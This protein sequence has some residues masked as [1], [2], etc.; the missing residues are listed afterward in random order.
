M[1]LK[2]KNWRRKEVTKIMD[3]FFFFFFFAI[4]LPWMSYN[5]WLPLGPYS[6]KSMKAVILYCENT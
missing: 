4:Y 5:L 6:Y 2:A 3:F 1:A